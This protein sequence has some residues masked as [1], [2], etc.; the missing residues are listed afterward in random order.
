[1]SLKVNNFGGY[2][3]FKSDSLNNNEWS[4]YR[5]NYKRGTVMLRYYTDRFVV[6]TLEGGVTTTANIAVNDLKFYQIPSAYL[7]AGFQI[8]FGERPPAAPILNFDPG[9]SG[10][11]PNYI[12]E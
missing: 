1:M 9:E 4:L 10:F 6:F 12:V 2:N 7:K 8:R 5:F 3:F 11:D